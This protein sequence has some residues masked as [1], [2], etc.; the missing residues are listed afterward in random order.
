MLPEN[1]GLP[2]AQKLACPTA[3][4]KILG[5]SQVRDPLYLLLPGKF[6]APVGSEAAARKCLDPSQVRDLLY[7]RAPN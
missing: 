2:L 4:S 1:F 7:H 6:W 5:P 3:A